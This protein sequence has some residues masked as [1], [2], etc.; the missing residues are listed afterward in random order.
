ML[1]PKSGSSGV[2]ELIGQMNAAQADARTQLG[3]LLN[4][5]PMSRQ[6]PLVNNRIPSLDKVI[7]EE[8]AKFRRNR[9]GRF[10][11]NR[12]PAG[13]PEARAR[14]KGAC[15]GLYIVGG[16]VIEPQRQQ[17]YLE[18]IAQPNPADYPL[19]PKRIVSFITGVASCMLVYGRAWLLVASVGEHSAA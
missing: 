17:L 10:D 7:A 5:S 12:V 2:L 4:N 18:T 16:S 9:L 19:F 1:D 15:L 11:T 3:E 13:K 8:R 14:R 6:I